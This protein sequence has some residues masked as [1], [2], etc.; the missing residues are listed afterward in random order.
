MHTTRVPP[1]NIRRRNAYY[2]DGINS[3]YTPFI[4][5]SIRRLFRF[6]RLD[7]V[8]IGRHRISRLSTVYRP[9]ARNKY[10][11][12]LINVRTSTSTRPKSNANAG[13]RAT[14]KNYTEY[15]ETCTG[16]RPA[17]NARRARLYVKSDLE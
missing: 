1:T 15:S 5:C 17:F 7:F 3:K 9:E 8:V 16:G 12:N 6:F 14:I 11:K 13:I 2:R 4:Q 10:S